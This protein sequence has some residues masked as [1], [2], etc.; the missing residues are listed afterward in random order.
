MLLVSLLYVFAAYRGWRFDTFLEDLTNDQIGE[1]YWSNY[2]SSIVNENLVLLVYAGLMWSR[3]FYQ[4]KLIKLSAEIFAISEKMIF[5]MFTYAIFYFSV[6]F[7]FGVVGFVLF[8]DVPDFASLNTALFTLFKATIQS[9]DVDKM[10]NARVGPFLG[11]TYFLSF[12]ILNL[13]LIMNLIVARLAN[14]YKQYNKKRHLLVLLNT[15]FEREVSEA[16]DKYSCLVSAPFP[17]NLLN[18]ALGSLAISLRSP[19][20]NIAI[21]NI[22]YLP[23]SSTCLVSFT[24]Y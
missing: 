19:A 12:L 17:L 21:L 20:A 2:L 22:Y 4:S 1:R 11:Y 3:T 10:Q 9:Y 14:V 7:L 8:Y 18:F 15:L 5:E 24:L 16:D 23:I 6:L 13:I